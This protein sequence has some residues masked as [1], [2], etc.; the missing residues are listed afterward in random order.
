MSAVVCLCLFD[1]AQMIILCEEVRDA[2]V[3]V[4]TFMQMTRV[5]AVVFIVP[6]A[7]THGMAHPYSGAQPDPITV[8]TLERLFYTPT[9][10]IT[11]I[12]PQVIAGLFLATTT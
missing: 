1:L 12:F 5:L 11:R 10:S 7:A 8:G 3:T 6:F 2:D 4:V 9:V